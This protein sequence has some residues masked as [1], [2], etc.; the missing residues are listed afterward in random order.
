MSPIVSFLSE[1][2][3]V[4]FCV[5]AKVSFWGYMKKEFMIMR[6][7]SSLFLMGGWGEV[8]RREYYQSHIS[9]VVI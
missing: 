8:L 5:G 7:L 1:T 2:I 6:K 9:A 4:S 3:I